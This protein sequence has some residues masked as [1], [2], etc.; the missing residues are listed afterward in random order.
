MVGPRNSVVR[1]LMGE[2]VPL[3]EWVTDQSDFVDSRYLTW[4]DVPEMW[5]DQVRDACG[6]EFAD[7]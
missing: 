5:I 7:Y 3:E 1:T 4:E 2:E 6:E